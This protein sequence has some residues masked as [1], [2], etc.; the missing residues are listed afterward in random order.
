MWRRFTR[1]IRS[2][3]GFF[4]SAAENP[5]IILEQN[6][7]D[8]NDQV[9]RMNESI[10]MVKA[11]VTLLEKEEAKYKN[12]INDLTA[13][14]KAAIQANRDDLA[15]SFATQLEQVRGALARNQG[16]LATARAA[17]DKAMVVK[18]AFLREKER[19]TQEALN[20]IRDYR[21]A[22]WQK[23]VADAMES[24]EVAGISQTHDEMVRKIEEETAVNEARMEMALGNVD[25]QKIKIE[26]EAEK[27]RANEL[28]KQFKVEMGLVAPEPS[29]PA[30]E[31]TIGTKEGQKTT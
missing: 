11:N 22:Q 25:Q 24:F 9:P 15:G 4:I 13:K 23:K 16:Q 20:A 29:A 12:D 28:V 17:C 6:I 27:L 30:M 1:M 18:Q 2:F 7:R 31:K 19:K 3:V 10:A 26:E 14:V 5:E 8:M 21:R